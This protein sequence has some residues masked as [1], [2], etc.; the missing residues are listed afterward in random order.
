MLILHAAVSYSGPAGGGG[1]VSLGPKTFFPLVKEGKIAV[2]SLVRPVGISSDGN[3]L[4]LSDGTN[5][6]A[7]GGVIIAATGFQSSWDFIC[8]C[9]PLL[10]LV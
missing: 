5:I 6:E 9:P 8:T 1:R 4:L 3:S 10:L 7:E 2:R